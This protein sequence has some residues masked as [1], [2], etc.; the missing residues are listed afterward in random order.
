MLDAG[1]MHDQELS[2]HQVAE[3]LSV[4]YM[5]VYRYV[6]LGQIARKQSRWFLAY[7]PFGSRWFPGR[8]RCACVHGYREGARRDAPWAD[9]FEQ[10]LIAG[11][12]RGHGG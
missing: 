2:L 1:E 12:G 6:R 5:T 8:R 10:R 9:R 11:D 3:V 7:S 4:H